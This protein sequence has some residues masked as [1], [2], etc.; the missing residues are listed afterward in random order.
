MVTGSDQVT[1]RGKLTS[2]FLPW[3]EATLPL[4]FKKELFSVLSSE[5]G[6]QIKERGLTEEAVLADFESWQKRRREARGR[7]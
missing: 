2:V 5:V 4:D 6:R 7:R 1:R 3:P